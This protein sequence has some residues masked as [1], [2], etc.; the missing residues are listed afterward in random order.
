MLTLDYVLKTRFEL[1][2]I[3]IIIKFMCMNVHLHI[4]ACPTAC[5]IPME[6]RESTGSPRT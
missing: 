3:I 2:I 1:I 5:L 6:V 4:Y